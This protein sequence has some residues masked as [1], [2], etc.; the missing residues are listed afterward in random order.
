[1]YVSE[2]NSQSK[3]LH[4]KIKVKGMINGSWSDWFGG[5]SISTVV[6]TDGVQ[7]TFLNGTFMDQAALRGVLVKLWDLNVTLLEVQLINPNSGDRLDPM[8]A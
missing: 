5:I 1:M 8:E 3:H 2:K 4:Y 6:E 7:V